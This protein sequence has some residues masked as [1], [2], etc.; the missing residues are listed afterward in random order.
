[1]ADTIESSEGLSKDICTGIDADDITLH[2]DHAVA[3]GQIVS[4]LLS[5]S[6]NHAFPKTLSG[7]IEVSLHR[8][9]GSMIELVV[10]DDGVGLPED[11][12]L[13]QTE[14]LG[15]RLI[16]ALAM[17]LSGVVNVESSGGTRVQITFPEKQS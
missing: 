5:N 3:C 16:N 12:D 14:T 6:L 15:M 8:R 13:E 9:D 10:A 11:F 1:M 7:T 2:V 4:E 17:Q